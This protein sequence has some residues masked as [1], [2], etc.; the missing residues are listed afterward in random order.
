MRWKWGPLL[1]SAGELSGWTVDSRISTPI[2]FLLGFP[3]EFNGNMGEFVSGVATMVLKKLAAKTYQEIALAWD[4]KN[5]LN[6]LEDS[7]R[8]IN[9]FMKDAENKQDRNNGII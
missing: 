4:L 8:I 3:F 7:M 9:A 6:R 2:C 1:R 5:D